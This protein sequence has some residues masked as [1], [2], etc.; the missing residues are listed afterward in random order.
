MSQPPLRLFVALMLP[1]DVQDG[2]RRVS[3]SWPDLRERNRARA[4]AEY[5][6]TLKFLGDVG[7]SAAEDVAD[8]L[9]PAFRGIEPF[10]VSL[11]RFGAF[12][13]EDRAAVLWWG[14][15]AGSEEVKTCA[16]RV[17]DALEPLGFERETRSFTPHVTLSRIRPPANLVSWLAKKNRSPGPGGP[18]ARRFDASFEASEVSLVRSEL[19]R[20]GAR[21]HRVRSYALGGAVDS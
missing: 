19:S 21:Y 11:G 12:P 2:I 7:P 4:A 13:T 3:R 14:A 15:D 5:H 8:A 18:P 16:G 9:E 1:S 17:E 10:R 6:F 20:Q